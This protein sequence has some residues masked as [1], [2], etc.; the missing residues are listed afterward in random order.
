[1]DGRP[2]SNL[3]YA[4]PAVLFACFIYAILSAFVKEELSHLSVPGI[5]FWR[6]LISLSLFIPW[7][8]YRNRKTTI[9][10]KPKSLK[11]YWVRVGANLAALYLYFAALKTLSIGMTSLLFNMLPLFVPIVARVWKKIPINHQLWWGFGVALIG[12][13][14]V[15]APQGIE[16][17][18]EMLFAIGAGLCGAFGLVSLRFTHYEEP[19]YRINFYF[20]LL[21]FI[22]TVPM[23]FWN[24]DESWRSLSRADI[25]PLAAIGVTGFLYQQAFSLALKNGPARFLAPFMYST[26]IWGIILDWWIWNTTFTSLMWLGIGLVILGNVLIYLLYPKKDL[27]T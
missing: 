7:M 12:V 18:R 13:A 8:F 2:K 27:T 10:L 23:T 24:I 5:L 1:M 22:M 9:N 26:V 11:L 17:N 21:A 15:L 14:F 19:A 16:W 6:Y 20:F 3:R 25:V 4:I